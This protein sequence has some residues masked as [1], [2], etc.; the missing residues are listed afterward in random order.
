MF[1]ALNNKPV[2]YIGIVSFVVGLLCQTQF[3]EALTKAVP[4]AAPWLGIVFIV[5]GFAAAYFGMPST[6]ATS[7]SQN[8][9]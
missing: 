8:G 5:A 6:V 4:A 3:Q 2:G 7:A 1:L 9:K